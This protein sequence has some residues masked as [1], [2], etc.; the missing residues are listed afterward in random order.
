MPT[1]VRH[2][3]HIY[4]YQHPIGWSGGD[5]SICEKLNDF[6]LA[7]E[8]PDDEAEEVAVR[9]AL[10]G[11]LAGGEII[12]PHRE[13]HVLH[14]PDLPDVASSAPAS[15]PDRILAEP[16]EDDRSAVPG[17]DPDRILEG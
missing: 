6:R 3:E 17:G 7:G 15:N 9:H 2:L 1:E 10:A 14:G 8:Y 4:T 13:T 11:I 12:A 16:D 5:R